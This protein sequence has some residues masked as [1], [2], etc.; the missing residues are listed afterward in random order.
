MTSAQKQKIANLT[1][2]VEEELEAIIEL[3][4]DDVQSSQWTIEREIDHRIFAWRITYD[5]RKVKWTM[6]DY[7]A[8]NQYNS[9]PLATYQT[10]TEVEN[11]PL[12]YNQVCAIWKQ[13]VDI[14]FKLLGFVPAISVTL[15][16]SLLSSEKLGKWEISFVAMI[17]LLIT[18]A[19]KIYDQ[20]NSELHDQL[21]SRGRK[22]E[23]EMG[24]DNGIFMGRKKPSKR[25]LGIKV[26]HDIINLIY[27]TCLLMWFGLAIGNHTEIFETWKHVN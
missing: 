22:I 10:N 14:R 4:K 27:W 1:G 20:R 26:Q 6:K 2:I 13:L 3:E 25:F 8:E 16:Y 11:Y 12:L 21:I 19:I 18:L 23:E 9:T 17:G 7:R 5:K 24:V 15:I